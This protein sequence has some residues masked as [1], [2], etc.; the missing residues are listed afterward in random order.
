M[1]LHLI[2]GYAG[3]PH[4][5]SADVGA[6]NACIL[7][8]E[9]CVIQSGENFAASVIT[10]NQIRIYDG[11][12]LMQGRHVR[13][14]KGNYEDITIENGTQNMN[15]NDLIVVR[16][17]KNAESGIESAVFAVIKG[18]ET[19][20][21]AVDPKYTT[22]DILSGD[23]V[24]HEMPLYRVSLSGIN[25]NELV[26][27]F[28]MAESYTGARQ[29]I[30]MIGLNPITTTDDD[31]P[32]N[33]AKL[34]SGIAYFDAKYLTNQPVTNCF[35]ENKVHGNVVHQTCWRRGDNAK[36]YVR[37]GST[38]GWEIDWTRILDEDCGR[39][40]VLLWTNAK[41][42][43]P[44][45]SQT[46]REDVLGANFSQYD[47]I[48]IEFRVTDSSDFYVFG[49]F[50]KSN[51]SRQFAFTK[52]TSDAVDTIILDRTVTAYNSTVYFGG[53]TQKTLNG[54]ALTTNTGA[55]IPIRI[56]GIKGVQ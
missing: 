48:Q 9:D 50:A 3:K 39:Q 15:R 41:P 16:Y 17:T 33:W 49:Y 12:L 27:L 35:V 23:C 47:E 52:Q 28:N 36:T 10:N 21:T 55:L 30:N 43:S 7:G 53:G 4:I 34:G 19:T 26:P 44:F 45:A 46:L 32:K 29:N 13:I 1:S 37:N 56:W 2:T 42:S 25:V 18:T 8:N 31:T 22:G 54:K 20:D 14:T 51:S 5:T 24:L 6:F 11:Q 40:K 38:S